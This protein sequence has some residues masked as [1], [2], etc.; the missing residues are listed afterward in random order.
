MR[1][2]TEREAER[3]C[4]PYVPT[5]AGRRFDS[6]GSTRI[7]VAIALASPATYSR[8]SLIA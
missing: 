2:S 4:L 6:K 5:L 8:S 7:G 1:H 3:G